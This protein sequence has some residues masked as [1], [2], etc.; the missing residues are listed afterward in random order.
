MN[1]AHG[2]LSGTGPNRTYTP[3][4][5]YS[6]PDSFTF[7]VTDTGDGSAAPL[8]SSAATVNITVNDKVNPTVTA[9]ANLNLGTGPGATTCGLFITETT[10]GTATA[11]DNSGVVSIQRNGVP[12]G[13]IFPVGTTTITYIATDGAGNSAQAT[14]TVVVFDNT[15]PTITMNGNVISLT[16]PN[17][18]HRTINVSDLVASAADNCDASVNLSKVFIALVTSD[19]TALG[20]AGNT[21]DDIVISGDAKS[22]NLRAERDGNGDGRVYTITFRVKD[23]AGNSTSTTGKVYVPNG[24]QTPVDSGIKYTVNGPIQ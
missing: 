23:Q 22:V 1:P 19:E 11:S 8:T 18:G 3:A 4:L 15:A 2:S 21:P 16:P 9:P 12:A 14:Q 13:N 24:G 7:T 5:D 20:N 17:H 6:G 10:L